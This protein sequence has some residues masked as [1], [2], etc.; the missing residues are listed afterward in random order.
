QYRIAE[1][2]H[3]AALAE[4]RGNLL[5]VAA[6]MRASIEEITARGHTHIIT[7]VF[8]H[9]V[10]SPLGFHT[11]VL[12]LVPV[13]AHERGEL[14]R[15]SRR[16]TL[17]LDLKSSYQRR[18]GAGFTAISRRAGDR[19]CTTASPPDGTTKPEDVRIRPA[20]DFHRQPSRGRTNGH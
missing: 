11:R 5:V 12:G 17:L 4:H 1:I 6:L 8:E 16:I 9:N 7:D 14:N 10:H 15:A 3:F 20:N 13:A 19:A 2:G 18:G